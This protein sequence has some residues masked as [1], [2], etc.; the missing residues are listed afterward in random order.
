MKKL[1]THSAATAELA[2]EDCSLVPLFSIMLAALQG[3]G[4]QNLGFVSKLG[5]NSQVI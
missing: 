5:N 4:T 3:N 1:G 2:F